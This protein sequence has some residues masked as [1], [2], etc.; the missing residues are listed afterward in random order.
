MQDQPNDQ[1]QVLCQLSIQVDEND[2]SELS[3]AIREIQNAKKK[4]IT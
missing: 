4:S 1:K 2:D 3:N